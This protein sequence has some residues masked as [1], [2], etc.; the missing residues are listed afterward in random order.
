MATG[1][2]KAATMCGSPLAE[3]LYHTTLCCLRLGVYYR[4][5]PSFKLTKGGGGGTS[6]AKKVSLLDDD[7]TDL[8][9]E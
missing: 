6:S 2:W 4:Y 9:I 8:I 5:L 3:D 7:D 1:L